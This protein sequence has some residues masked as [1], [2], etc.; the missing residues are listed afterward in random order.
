[1][2]NA[3]ARC[4]DAVV[5]VDLQPELW[6]GDTAAAVAYYGTAFGAVVEH[7]VGGP[8]DTDGVVQLSVSGARFWVAGSS[9][10]LGRFDA[11]SIGGGTARFLLVVEDPQSVTDGAV[12][13]GGKLASAVTEEH[14]WLLGRVVD[15]FGH[16][17]EIGRPLGAWPP[18]Q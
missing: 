4:D 15:P 11:R 16:E 14:G 7:R 3:D 5:R 1:V 12:E 2:S 17:W 6:V 8:D 13:A 18:A 9:E 10:Q